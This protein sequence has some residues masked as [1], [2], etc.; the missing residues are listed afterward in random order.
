MLSKLIDRT[1]QPEE[2]YI[3][4]AI[5]LEEEIISIVRETIDQVLVSFAAIQAVT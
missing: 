5:F 2:D 1:K 4:A 3:V